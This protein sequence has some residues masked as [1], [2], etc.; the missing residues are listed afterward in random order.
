MEFFVD[1][2]D[3]RLICTA[4]NKVMD[5]P[6]VVECGHS[7]CTSCMQQLLTKKRVVCPTCREPVSNDQVSP[8][9]ADL[10]EKLSKLSLHCTNQTSGCQTVTNLQAMDNHLE[11]ECEYRLVPCEH[12]GCEISVPYVELGAHMDTCDYRIVECKVCKIC[13]PRKDMPAHQA[14][15]RCFEQ[16]NKRRRVTSARKIS[17]D[18]REHRIDLVRDRHLTEQAE[19]HLVKRH[20]GMDQSMKHRRAMSAGPVLMRSIESRVGSAVVVPHYSRNL[21]S[22]ALDSCRDCTN[23]FTAGRRPSARRH[24]HAKVSDS[25]IMYN[26]L[27]C[28][29]AINNFALFLFLH[30]CYH[31]S[32]TLH[33]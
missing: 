5:N 16:L 25:N 6:V 17:Q 9:G 15:K 3:E 13:V 1:K 14:V 11:T 8:A 20:Y 12:Q 31:L 27:L 2:V 7:F 19:R 30:V 32:M 29:S 28:T 22:A 4:C 10:V 26:R 33:L 24:S 23:K 21:R 18:L